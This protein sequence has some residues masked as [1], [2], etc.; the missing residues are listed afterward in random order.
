MC[1][2]CLSGLPCHKPTPCSDFD[3]LDRYDPKKEK[4]AHKMRSTCVA[5]LSSLSCFGPTPGSGHDPR[6]G[7]YSTKP[8]RPVWS[9][10]QAQNPGTKLQAGVLHDAALD[11]VHQAP[12]R[13]W[14]QAISPSDP[15]TTYTDIKVRIEELCPGLITLDTMVKAIWDTEINETALTRVLMKTNHIQARPRLKDPCQDRGP[16]TEQQASDHHDVVQSTVHQ[17]LK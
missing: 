10:G 3:S 17:A 12:E 9:P 4:R 1:P 8:G 13:P 6:P 7:T 14:L 16:D 11:I 5:C 15:T 2:F